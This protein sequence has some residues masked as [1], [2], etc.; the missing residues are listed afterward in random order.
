MVVRERRNPPHERAVVI[1]LT[2][3]Y[4]D[5]LDGVDLRKRR[6]G[7]TFALRARDALLLI[8]EGWAEAVAERR[9]ECPPSARSAAADPG[10]Q[11]RRSRR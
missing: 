9:A 8:A 11:R 10:R 3:K 2:H 6:V 4:A 1:R 7:D 5:M